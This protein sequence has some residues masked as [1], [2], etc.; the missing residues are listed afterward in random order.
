M[1]E[2][3]YVWRY[4]I[5]AP[6]DASDP[7]VRGQAFL[8][9]YMAPMAESVAPFVREMCADRCTP[10]QVLASG[11]APVL[12]RASE[13][14]A[15]TPE[16]VRLSAWIEANKE[17][18]EALGWVREMYAWDV[19]VARAGVRLDAKAPPDSPL[20]L[21]PPHDAIALAAGV[22]A[23]GGAG[24]EGGQEA[25]EKKEEPHP[26][27]ALFHYTWGAIFHEGSKEGKEA[28][29]FDKRDYTSA[30]DAERP[31]ALTPPP[32]WAE[33]R[34]FLQDGA[35]VTRALR[36][37]LAEMVGLLNAAGA[38]LLMHHQQADRVQRPAR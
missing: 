9:D 1:L 33:G 19:A 35:H 14:R 27:P 21:Q 38:E 30:A 2:T 16:W 25:E 4:P 22:A 34:Y 29:R 36:D 11:P 28:W 23:E 7:T 12:L 26:Q 37:T 8:F 15:A 32:E 3:D 31:P 6:G 13:L 17:A 10:E 18:R 5:H 20:C 24:G